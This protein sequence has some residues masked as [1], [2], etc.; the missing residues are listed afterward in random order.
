MVLIVACRSYRE[1]LNAIRISNIHDTTFFLALLSCFII[2]SR[3]QAQPEIL[4]NKR[5]K[6]EP[7]NSTGTIRDP[8]EN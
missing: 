8:D 4:Q 1:I 3:A 2:H 5:L 6:K 7:S